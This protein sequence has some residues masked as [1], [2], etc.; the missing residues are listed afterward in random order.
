[1]QA[2]KDNAPDAGNEPP[3]P[4]GNTDAAAES[5]LMIDFSRVQ[6]T[7]EQQRQLHN[8]L[9]HAFP[10]VDALARLVRFGLNENLAVIAGGS[11]LATVVFNL[12]T[13]AD[14]QDRLGDLLLAAKRD[15]SSNQRLATF[16]EGVRSAQVGM[17]LLALLDSNPPM[18][19]VHSFLATAPS[20]LSS[21]LSGYVD[22]LFTVV[23]QERLGPVAFDFWVAKLYNHSQLDLVFLAPLD[24]PMFLDSGQPIAAIKDAVA[25]FHLFQKWVRQD[26]NSR[27]VRELVDSHLSP[28][29]RLIR[30]SKAR[31]P[32][33]G[34]V[35]RQFSGVSACRIFAS[36]RSRLNPADPQHRAEYVAQ[37][38]GDVTIRTYDA[39]VDCLTEGHRIA[40]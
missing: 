24:Q 36:R 30:N 22:D 9:I 34:P 4:T 13:W 15:N 25:Q 37:L 31:D 18:S 20:I 5:H 28:S 33:H 29:A 27:Y 17:R 11:D 23:S 16:I 38:L 12:I 14:A 21:C 26:Y 39:L 40:F 35:V 7:G 8:V 10:N 3:E 2:D 32:Y 19:A 1:M 6:L